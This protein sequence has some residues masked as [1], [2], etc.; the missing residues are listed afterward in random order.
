VAS[1]CRG[2]DFSNNASKKQPTSYI[3]H[4]LKPRLPAISQNRKSL[5]FTFTRSKREQTGRDK[6]S[7]T[8][9]REKEK[10]WI[11]KE[12]NGAGLWRTERGGLRKE[13]KRWVP[14]G[15]KEVGTGRR[16]KGGQPEGGKRAGTRF[17]ASG[18]CHESSSPSH[19]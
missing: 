10:R 8:R 19:C 2:L 12:E 3:T 4:K 7:Y 11:G 1:R 14:G 18:F 13:E 5:Y 16:E 17:F 9:R 15:G 6:D